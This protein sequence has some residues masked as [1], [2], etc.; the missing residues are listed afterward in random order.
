MLPDDKVD[1]FATS[2][3]ISFYSFSSLIWSS[4]VMVLSYIYFK[5]IFQNLKGLSDRK[6]VSLT[7]KEYDSAVW[8]FIDLKE[9]F[10]VNACWMV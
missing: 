6:V 4:I 2:L 10:K 5:R 1:T 9:V 8:F 7:K 3:L